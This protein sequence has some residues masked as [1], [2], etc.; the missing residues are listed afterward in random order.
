M[1]C[2]AVH[3]EDDPARHAVRETWRK[4]HLAFLGAHADRVLAAGAL[5]R[6]GSDAPVGGLW[7]VSAA[8]ELQARELIEADPYFAH[9]L[10]RTVRVWRYEAA[11]PGRTLTL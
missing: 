10:R 9:G 4:S 8:S 5:C 2:Y 3:F 11:L 6:E 1:S 7:L